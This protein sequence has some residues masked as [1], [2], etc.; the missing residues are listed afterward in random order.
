MVCYCTTRP[1]DLRG[2]LQETPPESWGSRPTPRA[3]DFGQAGRFQVI[4]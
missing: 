1:V 2:E 4:I 3:A